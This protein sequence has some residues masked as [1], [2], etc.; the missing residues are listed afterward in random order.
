MG[1]LFPT[2]TRSCTVN[3]NILYCKY[4]S[5][6]VRERAKDDE[7][8]RKERKIATGESFFSSSLRSKQDS[9]FLIFGSESVFIFDGRVR[10]R[11]ICARFF[12]SYSHSFS[13]LGDFFYCN[14]V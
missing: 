13:A 3:T 4:L 9:V 11:V 14:S 5:L 8:Q 1:E 2:T 6:S 12:K 7:N 10:A